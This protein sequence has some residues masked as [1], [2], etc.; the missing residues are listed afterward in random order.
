M[1]YKGWC[2]YLCFNT[3]CSRIVR[4]S[5][6]APWHIG[7]RYYKTSFNKT[8]TQFLRKL[9]SCWWRFGNLQWWDSVTMV[10]VRNKGKHLSSVN[11]FAKTIHLH[12]Q[13]EIIII[14]YF[15]RHAIFPVFTGIPVSW[16]FFSRKSISEIHAYKRGENRERGLIIY[17]CF[18]KSRRSWRRDYLFCINR[19]KEIELFTEI[20]SCV[21]EQERWSDLFSK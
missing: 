18:V 8:W 5:S 15:C 2:S 3:D 10:S 1:L 7:Y 9:K 17:I 16:I 4:H 21:S 12:Q 6:L 14:L 19:T 20:T 11:H 13:Q